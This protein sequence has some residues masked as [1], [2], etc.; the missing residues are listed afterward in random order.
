MANCTLISIPLNRH[1]PFLCACFLLIVCIVYYTCLFG[2]VFYSYALHWCGIILLLRALVN[3]CCQDDPSSAFD[4]QLSF[5]LREV[6][7]E[8]T[9]ATACLF[10]GLQNGVNGWL[11]IFSP[12]LSNLTWCI[13][14]AYQAVALWGGALQPL[15]SNKAGYHSLIV[16]FFFFFFFTSFKR[17]TVKEPGFVARHSSSSYCHCSVNRNAKAG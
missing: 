11:R 2:T 10:G 5:S 7:S 8:V 15:S 17:V 3:Q 16:Y 9:D 13:L 14:P 4:A 12:G 6:W 1:L